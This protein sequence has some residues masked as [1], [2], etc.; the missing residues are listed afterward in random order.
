MDLPFVAVTAAAKVDKKMTHKNNKVTIG[1]PV[2]NGEAY[3]GDALRS[4]LSQSYDNFELI[5]SDNA[6]TDRTQEICL[7]FAA[8]DKRV[9]YLRQEQNLGAVPNFNLVFEVSDSEYFKW[10]AADDICRPSYLE[11]CVAILDADLTVAWCHSQ[12]SHIDSAGN[13]LSEPESLDVSYADRQAARPSKRFQAILFSPDGCLDSYGLMRSQV[14]RKTPLYLPYYG[15]EKVFIAEMALLGRFQEIPETLFFA[16]VATAGS[17]NIQSAA[18]QQ[19]F[20]DT[21]SQRVPFTRL[22]FLQGYLNAIQRSDLSLSEK[23]KCRILV[24]RWVMQFA[25]WKSVLTKAASGRGVGGRNAVRLEQIKKQEE[26]A[27]R[28]ADLMS[29]LAASGEQVNFHKDGSVFR[30][31]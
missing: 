18:E 5:I 23:M 15:P 13:L 12:S 14:I 7:E 30:E 29:D 21:S 10:A 9:R 2:Y 27:L 11:K 4:L 31:G 6:S 28:N 24:G 19:A 25:K 20:I 8:K 16:R 17:G 3:L 22:R 26:D 1:L